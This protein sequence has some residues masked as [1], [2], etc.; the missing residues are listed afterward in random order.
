MKS[1]FSIE[2]V[3]KK[4]NLS[5]KIVRRHIASTKLKSTKIGGVIRISEKDVKSFLDG[6]TVNEDGQS[7]LFPQMG[8]FNSI[9]K[10]RKSNQKKSDVVNWAQIDNYWDNVTKTDLTF[11]DLFS[12]AGGMS[13]GLEMAGFQG[14]FGLDNYEPAVATYKRNFSHPI[15]NG[16]ITE[17]TVKTEFIKIVQEKLNNKALNIIAG[18]FPCQ[19]FSMAGHRIVADRRNSLY[20]DMLEIVKVL[21]PEFVIMENVVGLRSM[22]GGGVEQ[23]ILKD[24]QK[25][26]YKINV[27][28]LNSAD[29]S[30][31]QKRKRVIFIANKI[32]ADN[33]HP[34]PFLDKINYKTTK[35]AIKDLIDL[36]DDPNLNH[37]RTKHSKNM[38]ERISA[39]EEGK[40][41]YDNYSDSWKKCPWDEAS[42]TI[43]ENHGGVNLHP[44]R[45]R[46]L[47][48][49]EMARIQSFPDDFFFEGP[50]SKQL[51]QI[52][53]AV[54]PLLAKAIGIAV[55]KSYE[56]L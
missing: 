40:S 4:L 38:V 42:C 22:L 14:L 29:Y 12:G 27:T 32:G 44:R 17:N 28:T 9:A 7:T 21:Q 53:N 6:I 54:P 35:D 47:T 26:G 10:D 33:F 18:G 56:Q 15:F 5:Q 1:F 55:R 24:Y 13:K 23:K 11:V 36:G 41:L 50:K 45:P 46:V 51:V 37:I 2:Q 30:V 34:M 25:N 3:S 43:K 52:G 31:P 49:R 16:D 19:G 20:V 39:V 8:S 48:A